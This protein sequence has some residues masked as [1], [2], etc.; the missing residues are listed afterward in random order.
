MAE[1]MKF[2]SIKIPTEVT[3][4]VTEAKCKICDDTGV[5]FDNNGNMKPCACWKKHQ[6][7]VKQK[8]AGMPSALQNMNF[9]TF[10][11]SFYPANENP[12]FMHNSQYSYLDYAKNAKSKAEKFVESVMNYGLTNSQGILFQGQVGSGKTHLAASITNSLIE[13]NIDVLFLV[14]PDF[15]DEMRMSY[16]NFGEFNEVTLMNKAKNAKVLVLDDLGTHNFSE[17][18]KNKLFTLINYR[19]NNQLPMIITT[20]L[21]LDELKE[22]VG[23]R[24]ISRIIA[25]C[26]P[27][28]L[29]VK[30]DIRLAKIQR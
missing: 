17:W 28:L 10:D 19:L 25:G 2:D 4:P 16:G 18:T 7:A 14:V 11:L 21:N 6:L 15:L 9:E 26:T 22:V 29:P 3:E 20:N 27:C 1:Y 23:E 8:K 24:V 5:V 12:N 13:N 30:R